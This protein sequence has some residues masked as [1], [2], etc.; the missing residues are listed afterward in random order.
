MKEFDFIVHGFVDVI[1]IRCMI[2]QFC[3][4]LHGKVYVLGE[5]LARSNG[6]IGLYCKN[7]VSELC[8]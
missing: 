6:G 2:G 5:V 8:R 7:D 4:T 1:L 3:H